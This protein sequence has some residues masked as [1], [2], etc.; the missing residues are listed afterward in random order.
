MS[1]IL[2]S[3]ESNEWCTPSRYVDAARAL[4][5]SIDLDPASCAFAN[6]RVN[7]THYYTQEDNG[8]LHSWHGRVWCNPPYGKTDTGKSN[9]GIWSSKLIAEYESGHI[10]E[11]VLLVNAAMGETWFQ[12]LYYYHICLTDHRIHFESEDGTANQPTHS[13]AFVYFGTQHARFID[14]FSRFGTVVKRAD[15]RKRRPLVIHH[16]LW[17]DC[18]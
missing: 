18:K 3:S 4:M 12:P 9:Q 17:N 1:S 10:Q 6:Q 16:D 5:Y 11:A 13:N 14:L 8:L 15:E 2:L 7:A